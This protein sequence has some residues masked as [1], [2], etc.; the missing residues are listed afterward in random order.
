VIQA[1]PVRLTAANLETSVRSFFRACERVSGRMPDGFRVTERIE[2]R[3]STN[4]KRVNSDIL[5]TLTELTAPAILLLLAPSPSERV[6]VDIDRGVLHLACQRLP[7]ERVA[8]RVMPV[9]LGVLTTVLTDAP[10]GRLPTGLVRLPQMVTFHSA[11]PGVSTAWAEVGAPSALARGRMTLLKAQ[12]GGREPTV[13]AQEVLTMLYLYAENAIRFLASKEAR[14]DIRRLVMGRAPLLVDAITPAHASRRATTSSPSRRPTGFATV[15]DR[16]VRKTVPKGSPAVVALVQADELRMVT[17]WVA[18]VIMR[19]QDVSLLVCPWWQLRLTKDG[20]VAS[21]QVWKSGSKDGVLSQAVVEHLPIDVLYFDGASG[22]K[23]PCTQAEQEALH[24][25]AP[26][27]T[28][29]GRMIRR[30]VI[31]QV[32]L[33]ASRRGVMTNANARYEFW[34]AKHALEFT[35]REHE[36]LGG[37]EV[38]RPL[39]YS[40]GAEQVP[41]VLEALKRN[42]LYGIV[43]PT[44]GSLG[45]GLETVSPGLVRARDFPSGRYVV[46]ELVKDP[47]LVDGRKVDLRCHLLIDPELREAS[48]WVPPILAR[49]AGIPYVRGAQDA[50]NVNLTYQRKRKLRPVIVPLR[51]VIRLSPEL[52]HDIRNAVQVLSDQIIDAYFALGSDIPREREIGRRV[53][54]WGFDVALAVQ[55]G[56]LQA[57]LLENNTRAQLYRGQALCDQAMANM[58]GCH[59]FDA[60]LRRHRAE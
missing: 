19:R 36:L 12:S 45:H 27:Q 10:R 35:L 15:H 30:A 49:I 54:L 29:H 33:E 50:E 1:G 22:G 31:R 13:Y 60:L 39:T 48:G 58:I 18:K 34:D 44:H 40:A 55:H 20:A 3:L 51:D 6:R 59:H 25:L 24:H 32:L 7:P 2:I 9:L 23:R 16:R 11:E 21:G 38:P 4:D 56:Q 37:Q 8:Q 47:L 53:F 28:A 41:I 57:Y 43:K 46:Q 52:R 42:G 5:R 14:P 26:L 17:K